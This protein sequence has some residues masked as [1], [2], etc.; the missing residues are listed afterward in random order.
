MKTIEEKL[1]NLPTTPGVYFHKDKNSKIIY[2]GKA[3]NLR[4]RVRQYFQKSRL[5]DA[6]TDALVADIKDIDWLEVSTEMDALFVEAEMIRRYRPKYNILL[7]DDKSFIYVRIDKK[8]DH[9][10]VRLV[11]RPQDDGAE[12]IGPFQSKYIVDKALRYL[13]RAF[14]YSTHYNTV[15]NRAC[16]QAQL[17]LCPGLE[18][19]MT[20]ISQY[21][22][23][24]SSLTSYLKGSRVA[25]I[26]S[27]E[28][29]MNALA[30]NHEFEQAAKTRNQLTTLKYLDNKTIFSDIER[31]DLVRDHALNGLKDLLNL[32]DPPLRIE[33]FDISHMSGTDNVASNVVF[34]A[35]LPDKPSYRK[36][37]MRLLGNDDF[38]HMR[39]VMTRRFSERNIKSWGKPDLILIDGGKGQV[40]SALEVLE[41]LNIDIPLIGL[42]KQFE[43]I[44][45]PKRENN[46]W[47]F[48]VINLGL[49]SEIVKLLQRVRDESH[50]FALSYH[51]VLKR[52]RQTINSLDLIPGIGPSTRKLL[53]RKFGSYKGIMSAKPADIEEAIGPH[54]AK[55]L[56]QNL[57][58]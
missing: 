11:R 26:K 46:A 27:L 49:N 55:V 50:R 33:G 12:Y 52:K 22:H 1:Q 48:E 28:K 47:K 8:A 36:F 9:P 5:R 15:P 25:V 32:K 37:K 38:A 23:N 13:R 54:K 24:L 51:T 18:A 10:T 16:L 45:V 7:R 6:K 4:N 34:I 30:K 19:N 21:R 56:Q 17:G 40:S 42:A 41:E 57:Q 14:P 44:I 2:V 35:G 58:K 39:E 20:P 29:S 31:L 43:E 53:L 3:A